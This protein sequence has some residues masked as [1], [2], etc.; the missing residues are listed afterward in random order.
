MLLLKLTVVF[1]LVGMLERH[2]RL[3]RDG[4]NHEESR[5]IDDA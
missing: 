5:Q 3:P 4:L 2:G 1:A